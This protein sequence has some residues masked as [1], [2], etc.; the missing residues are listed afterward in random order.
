MPEGKDQ[1]KTEP[2]TPKRRSEARKKGQ[3]AVSKEVPSVII[4]F[5]ALS[6]LFFTGSWMFWGLRGFMRNIF[7]NLS[8]MNLQANSSHQFLTG[9]FEQIVSILAPVMVAVVIAG[10]AGNILQVGFLFTGETFVPKFSKLNPIKGMKRFVSIRSLVE[11]LKSLLKLLL[12]GV[13]AFL[14]I[15]KELENIPGLMQMGTGEI[16]SFICGVSIRICFYTCLVLIILAALDFAFQRWRFEKDLKMSKQEVKDELKQR[17]GDPK[18]KARIRRVQI[19]MARRRMMEA[20][21]DATV[22]ITNPTHLAVALKFDVKKMLA[23]VVVAKGAGLIAQRI[24][25]IAQKNNVVVVEHKPLA[26][27]LYK[28]VE[29]GALIPMELYQAVAEILAYVYRLKQMRHPL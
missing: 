29:I 13:I 4:L 24:K 14:M 19:E 15:R 26:Q 16:L 6:V 2:A 25:E 23:P 18:I 3:V 20:V 27:A 22:V 28:A 10:L 21:P 9:V 7:Q 5:S 8:S 17:E 1:E 11:L 12:V